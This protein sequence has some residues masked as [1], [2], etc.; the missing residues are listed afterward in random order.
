MHLRVDDTGQDMQPRAI[1]DLA[2]PLW[3]ETADVGDAALADGDIADAHT[4]V[5]YN[6]PVF[7]DEIVGLAHRLLLEDRLRLT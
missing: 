4:V 7:Q 1:N 5:V 3:C 2:G 6:R